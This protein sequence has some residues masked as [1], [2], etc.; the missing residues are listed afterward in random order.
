[1]FRDPFYLPKYGDLYF[2]PGNSETAE[3]TKKYFR[4]TLSLYIF[5]ILLHLCGPWDFSELFTF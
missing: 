4:F 2:S 1:M 3:V 5:N